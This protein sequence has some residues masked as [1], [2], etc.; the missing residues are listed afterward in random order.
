LIGITK[1][2]LG[3]FFDIQ[4]FNAV[5]DALYSYGSDCL[6]ELE[7]FLESFHFLLEGQDF[8][9]VGLFVDFWVDCGRFDEGCQQRDDV[10]GDRGIIRVVKDVSQG[11]M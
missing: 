11:P 8:I 6:L 4:F 7:L 9:G 5:D 3:E 1:V 2:V 10:L